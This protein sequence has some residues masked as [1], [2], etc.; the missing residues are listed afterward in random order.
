MPSL[1]LASKFDPCF[2]GSCRILLAQ[3]PVVTTTSDTN[4][5]LHTELNTKISNEDTDE[6]KLYMRGGQCLHCPANSMS[7]PGSISVDDCK[8]LQG[9]NH[10]AHTDQCEACPANTFKDSIGN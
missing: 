5:S 7:E 10:V 3:W 1:T 6:L 9:A 8:C 2:F 4:I